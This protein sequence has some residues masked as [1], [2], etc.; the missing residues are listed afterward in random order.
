MLRKT[1]LSA[2]SLLFL[3]VLSARADDVLQLIPG[4]N[5]FSDPKTGISMSPYG[6]LL[7]GNPAEFFCVDANPVADDA[8]WA[9]VATQL[10]N[11]TGY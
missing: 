2:L 6:G 8:T 10:T 5:A 3:A 4:Q 11:V 7:N 9:A 1:V